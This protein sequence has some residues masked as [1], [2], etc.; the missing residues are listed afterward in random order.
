MAEIETAPVTSPEALVPTRTGGASMLDRWVNSDPKA[1]IERVETM[2]KVLEQLR[3]ASIRA[4]YPPDWIIH[5]TVDRDGVVTK[6]IGYLQDSGAERAGKVWGIEVGNP[7]IEREDFPDATYSYHMMAEAWSKV[8]GE[9][10]DYAEGSRWSGDNFFAR[11]VK[12]PDKDRIDPT[13]VRKAAYANLHGR[14]VRALSGLNGVPLEMLRQAGVDIN[15]VIHVA[16]TQGAKGG[17]SSGAASVGTAEAVVAFGRSSGKKVSELGEADLDWYLKAYGENVENPEKAK[18]QKANRRI[19][20]A[21]K[22]EKERRD[23]AATHAAET[24]TQTPGAVAEEQAQAAPAAEPA[25]A[26]VSGRGKLTGDLWVRLTDAAGKQAIP[27][28][29]TLTKELFGQEIGQM[30]QVTDEQLATLAKVPEDNLKAVA[31]TL[32]KA[33]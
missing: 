27:L 31:K 21:L 10:L 20:D 13:D 32:P 5:S 14:A 4:T 2:V 11:Q 9:R 29:Q 8:T 33:K 17:E 25:E 3:V 1:A 18:Y 19:L 28:L 24:G 30:S 12:D 15:K 23:Q 6:Q 22:G 26:A 16:Y 7:A